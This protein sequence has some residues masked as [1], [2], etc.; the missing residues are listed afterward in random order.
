[1]V[2][3]TKTGRLREKTLAEIKHSK[4][5]T[6]DSLLTA[7]ENP[8]KPQ[9]NKH[10]IISEISYET[11]E[12][13]LELKVAFRLVPSRASFSRVFVELFFDG[14]KLSCCPVRIPQGAL[15]ADELEWPA[16]LDMR[17][18]GT[19][20]HIIRAEMYELWNSEE[21]LTIDSKEVT[22]NYVPVRRQDRYIKIPIVKKVGYE[23]LEIVSEP[24]RDVYREIEKE[25]KE[26]LLNKR[27]EW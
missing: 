5:T 1:M 14:Q 10:I 27:D 11:K 3:A 12:D 13:D 7:K 17:G 22:I 25:Q 9:N 18:I 21:R 20:Q 6:F 16:A 26:E 4:Q 15:S 8:S 19:G 23:D 2:K 24:T